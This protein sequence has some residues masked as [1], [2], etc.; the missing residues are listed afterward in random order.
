MTAPSPQCQPSGGE[1]LWELHRQPKDQIA[2]HEYSFWFAGEPVVMANAMPGEHDIL[3]SMVDALNSHASLTAAIG[4]SATTKMYAD[5]WDAARAR[6]AE[7]EAREWEAVKSSAVLKERVEELG[8]E[9]AKSCDETRFADFDQGCMRAF[10]AEAALRDICGFG[11][12]PDTGYSVAQA[13]RRIA[14]A[15]LSRIPGEARTEVKP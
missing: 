14:E 11:V 5:A 10:K 4:T 9:L 1:P 12:T 6:I 8:V 2:D 15:A 3:Q 7:L 13:M